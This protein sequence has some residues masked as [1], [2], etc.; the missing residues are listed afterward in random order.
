MLLLRCLKDIPKQFLLIIL[1]AKRISKGVHTNK[2]VGGYT[3]LYKNICTYSSHQKYL[4]EIISKLSCIDLL[5]W[6]LKIL[7]LLAAKLTSAWVRVF[8]SDFLLEFE[9][10]VL[11]IVGKWFIHWGTGFWERSCLAKRP[12]KMKESDIYSDSREPLW[13]DRQSK[14]DS[15]IK[16]WSFIDRLEVGHNVTGT[17]DVEGSGTYFSINRHP[18]DLLER[19]NISAGLES[20]QSWSQFS[21]PPQATFI[22]LSALQRDSPYILL[23]IFFSSFI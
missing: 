6:A 18:V 2:T 22:L 1:R 17:A 9:Q 21:L 8:F 23:A 20:S 11:C 5:S 15:R 12:L 14:E 7:N 19:G 13:A 16:Q 3:G 4:I 10:W